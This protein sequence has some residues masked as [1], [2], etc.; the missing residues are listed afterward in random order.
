MKNIKKY[1]NYVKEKVKAFQNEYEMISVI[2]VAFIIFMF[3]MFPVDALL[4]IAL[5]FW[6]SINVIK[7]V[8]EKRIRK[9][10]KPFRKNLDEVKE[11]ELTE[12]EKIVSSGHEAGHALMC[13]LISDLCTV[14]KITIVPEGIFLGH[15][16]FIDNEMVIRK[17]Y[18]LEQIYILIAG[19]VAEDVLFGEHCNGCAKDV[20]EVRQLACSM[21]NSGMGKK[22]AYSEI[23][24]AK[25]VDY[26]LQEVRR[27]ATIILTENKD[28]LIKLQNEIL[29]KGTL[30]GQQMLDVIEN[31]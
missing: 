16:D 25:E 13:Y 9:L 15:V 19:L 3:F 8:K 2:L 4:K 24:S 7:L 18:Y 10:I 23:D 28:V 11:P 20:M 1:L 6:L 27:R 12:E 21:L 14:E 29:K 5:A 22:L 31:E 30:N 26:F 17:K